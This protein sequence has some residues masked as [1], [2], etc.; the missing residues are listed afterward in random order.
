MAN[1]APFSCPVV[2]VDDAAPAAVGEEEG[3]RVRVVGPLRDDDVERAAAGAVEGPGPPRVRGGA[4]GAEFPE[5]EVAV[6]GPPAKQRGVAA[7]PHEKK[8]TKKTQG[9]HMARLAA[10]GDRVRKTSSAPCVCALPT[11]AVL[12]HQV[13]LAQ[14]SFAWLGV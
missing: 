2:G 5:E 13:S 3:R 1:V 10:L 14:V 7:R 8:H 4:R 12:K 11:R 9:S 6:V